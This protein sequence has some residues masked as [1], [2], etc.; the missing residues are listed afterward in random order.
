MDSTN[1]FTA[2]AGYG[3]FKGAQRAYDAIGPLSILLGAIGAY[4]AWQWLN[5]SSRQ[6]LRDGFGQFAEFCA[7]LMMQQRAY[8]QQFDAALPVVPTPSQ[9]A[10][11]APADAVLGRACLHRLAREPEGHLSAQKLAARVRRELPCADS[12]VRAIIREGSSFS[13]VYRGRWQ[14]GS[15]YSRA[16]L[17]MPAQ[18]T[19]GSRI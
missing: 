3:I 15:D 18:A 11:H 10:A 9:L 6:S 14:I 7:E 2:L 8:E 17:A 13:E 1:R 12:R 4:G 5:D 19:A 16:L